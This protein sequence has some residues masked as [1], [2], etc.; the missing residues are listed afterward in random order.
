MVK[1]I[2]VVVGWDGGG[3]GAA[4]YVCVGHLGGAGG[5][6]HHVVLALHVEYFVL[7]TAAPRRHLARCHNTVDNSTIRC[8]AYCRHI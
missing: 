7:G 4:L 5:P 6:A 1:I 8:F 2:A 3:S